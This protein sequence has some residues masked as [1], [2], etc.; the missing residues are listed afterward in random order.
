VLEDERTLLV[1]VTLKAEVRRSV[2]DAR[3]D[4]LTAVVIMAISARHLSFPD[5]MMR[6]QES[7]TANLL[8]TLPA[9]IRVRSAQK[10]RSLVAVDEVA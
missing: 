4:V 2:P 8:V 6:G 9:E 10:A 7:L 5:R 1:R 3:D